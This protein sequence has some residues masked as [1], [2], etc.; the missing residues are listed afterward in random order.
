[1]CI[2]GWIGAII[3][4]LG[5]LALL[6]IGAIA[7]IVDSS[8]GGLLSGVGIILGIVVLIVGIAN[9]VVVYWLWQMEKKG[10]TWTMIIEIIGLI[11]S[12]VQMNVV[13]IILSAIIVG[14]LWTKKDLFK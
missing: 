14:Y 1:M 13:S 4:I 12:L 6:G 8:I 9:L 7:G 2:L 10:W 5:G 3:T 11:L